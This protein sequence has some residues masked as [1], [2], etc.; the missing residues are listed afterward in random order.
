MGW[1][2]DQYVQPSYAAQPN[3]QYGGAYGGTDPLK[4]QLGL[5][6]SAQQWLNANPNLWDPYGGQMVAGLTPTQ[7]QARQQLQGFLGGDPSAYTRQAADATAGL[8]GFQPQNVTAAA[9]APTSAAYAGNVNAQNVSAPTTTYAGDV[10]GGSFL[11]GNL[12]AYMNPYT[13]N[14]V[15]VALGDIER[16]RQ[17]AN[18]QGARSASASTYGG[19]R[20]AL[21]EAETN[22]G[23]A[24]AA[25]RT[26]AQLRSQGF[27]TAAGLMGQDLSRGLTAG[28]ANQSAR[29]RFGEFGAGLG[30]QAQLANQG[31]GLQAGLANQA[32]R[33]GLNQFN[34]GQANQMGLANAEFAQ[35]AALANQQ[36][37]LAGA[38]LNLGAANQL[39][40]LGGD[41]FNQG[42]LGA[43]ALNQFGTQEQATH[44]AAY[45][46][47]YQEWLRSQ[48]GPMQG[49]NFLA[50]LNSGMPY[51]GENPGA[52]F[53]GG[54]MAGASIGAGFGPWGAGI[55]ALG[56][57]LLG[58]I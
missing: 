28:L 8:M 35:Q 22:R 43:S 17:I 16:S 21:I 12:G 51:G 40:S 49:F 37:G 41:L 31:A 56:G 53:A 18:A 36:A 15:D 29:A 5:Y 46:A 23:F 2:Q 48:F 34:A 6:Q 19:S 13:S 30:M 44:Q 26:S 25:A 55:G 27:D 3:Q 38:N 47:Q 42:L 52:G 4:Y 20:N 24:D 58:L 33:Q 50:G 7:A 57:G 39:G 9:A 45:D 32:T 10:G 1:I 54:A 14:V 11:G